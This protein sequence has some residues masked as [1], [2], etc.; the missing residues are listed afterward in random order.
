M[1]A[2][3]APGKEPRGGG[4]HP[5][6]HSKGFPAFF[7]FAR[8]SITVARFSF[9]HVLRYNIVKVTVEV[10]IGQV[11][12]HL[13]WKRLVY[14]SYSE[15]H[16]NSHLVCEGQTPTGGPSPGTIEGTEAQGTSI[17]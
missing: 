13:G 9:L 15:H 2:L 5:T 10:H 16:R 12:V 17:T 7:S 1:R 6:S 14:L 4:C 8:D 3:K 11:P